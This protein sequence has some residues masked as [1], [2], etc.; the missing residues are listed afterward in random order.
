MRGRT[1]DRWPTTNNKCAATH[2]TDREE[3]EITCVNPRGFAAW[4]TRQG[5][6]RERQRNSGRLE[7]WIRDERRGAHACEEA[8]HQYDA[9]LAS[10]GEAM[11]SRREGWMNTSDGDEDRASVR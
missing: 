10:R 5:E 11:E 7:R 8:R 2:S 4:T 3:P 6:V 9:V 1:R